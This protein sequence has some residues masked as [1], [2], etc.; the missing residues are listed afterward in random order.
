LPEN[1]INYKQNTRCIKVCH[2]LK[3]AAKL[4]VNIAIKKIT[5]APWLTFARQEGT[6]NARVGEGNGK[7]GRERGEE[8]GQGRER[9]GM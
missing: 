4:T 9:E 6:E 1:T 5:S 3:I 7:H 8:R 2:F